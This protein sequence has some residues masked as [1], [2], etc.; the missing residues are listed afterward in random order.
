[1]GVHTSVA[2][3][4]AGALLLLGCEHVSD[5][6]DMPLEHIARHSGIGPKALTVARS[7]GAKDVS[8]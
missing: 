2:S 1:M 4:L 3:H 5:V 7:F 6:Y 8:E